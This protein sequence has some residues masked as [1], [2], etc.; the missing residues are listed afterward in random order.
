[1]LVLFSSVDSSSRSYHCSYASSALNFHLGLRIIFLDFVGPFL[2]STKG[3]SVFCKRSIFYGSEYSLALYW[4]TNTILYW[5]GKVRYNIMSH[6]CISKEIKVWFWGKNRV[7][8]IFVFLYL[9]FLDIWVIKIVNV[10][11]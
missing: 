2:S 8:V 10:V 9:G 5:S 1:M 6:R 11:V 7:L 4:K 3:T